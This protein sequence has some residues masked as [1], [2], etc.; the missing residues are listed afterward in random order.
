[1]GKEIWQPLLCLGLVGVLLNACGKELPDFPA[2]TPPAGM[3]DSQAAAM[4]GA[5]LFRRNC[6]SCHG[7]VEEGRSS[8]ADFFQPPAPDFREAL[9]RSLPV[10][11]LYWRIATG[12]NA[13]PFASL[14]SVMPP[15]EL[16]LRE[17]EIWQLVA[18]LRSR[19]MH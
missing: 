5:E 7:R 17:E 11:Y 16:T 10:D 1:M 3:L 2:R 8:R 15:W 6:A 14:G 12:K 19:G 9:Y 13:E 4:A 18:Y